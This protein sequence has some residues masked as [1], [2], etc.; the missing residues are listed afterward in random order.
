MAEISISVLVVLTAMVP[1]LFVVSRGARDLFS[2]IYFLFL[3]DAA[4]LP[5]S[6]QWYRQQAT[7]GLFWNV[8]IMK[9]RCHDHKR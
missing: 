3:S 4:F 2:T 1:E 7:L 5:H 6:T 8:S 9:V